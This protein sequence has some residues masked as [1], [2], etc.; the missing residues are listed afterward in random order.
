MKNLLDTKDRLARRCRLEAFW[1][2]TAMAIVTPAVA[3]AQEGS[4]IQGSAS[5]SPAPEQTIGATD[6]TGQD[7][8]VTGIRAGLE[9]SINVK[10]KAVNVVDVISAED[11][12]KFPDNN[13]AESLQ[14]IPSVTI[15]RSELG[16]GR[17]INLRGLGTGFTRTEINGGFAINGLD[18]GVLAPEIFSRVAV[19]K[20]SSAS[21][22]E[23]GLAG[24]V[25]I[26]TIKPFDSP[27]LRI[28]AV[29]GGQVGQKSKVMPRTFGLISKNWDDRFGIALGVAYSKVDFRTNEIAYGPWVPF[30]LIANANALAT[31]PST[32]LDAATPRTAA[33]Y[34]YIEQRKN[35]GGTAAFQAKLGDGFDL[36]ADFLYAEI[37]GARHDDRPD[38][39]IEGNNAAPTNYTVE[40]GVVTSGTFAGVQNRVGTSYRPQ[41]QRVWQGTLRADL[42]PN[43][44]LTVSPAIA[45]AKRNERTEL[46]L[47]S[48]AIN[49][50]TAS[51]DVN[52][53]VPNFTSGSTDFLSN[54]QDFG[55]NVFIFDRFRQTTDELMAKI[56]AKYAFDDEDRFS[57]RFG[58]RYTDR[59]TSRRGENAGLYQGSPL[60]TANS[61]SLAGVAITRPFSVKGSPSQT[62]DRI[63]AVDPALAKKY[64]YPNVGDPYVAPEFFPYLTGN[65][66]RSFA[67]REETFAGY[68]QANFV[69]G[70]VSF[71]VGIRYVNTS[72][73]TEGTQLVGETPLARSDSGKSA[74]W[75]PAANARWEPIQNVVVHGALSRSLTR[76]DLDSLTPTQY[77]NSGPQTGTR[78]NPNLRPYTADQADLSVEWYW[79]PGSLLNVGYFY[80]DIKDL[81]T[82]RTVNEVATFPDQLTGLPTTGVIAF[83]EPANGNSAWVSGLEVGL[84]S[85]FYFLPGALSGF[86]TVLNYTRAANR[87]KIDNPDGTTLRQDL[88]GLSRNAYNAVLYYEKSG[89]DAR[90][91]YSWRSTYR[92][93]DP[94]GAQFGAERYVRSFGQLDFSSSLPVTKWLQLNFDV[95]NVLD[96]QRKEFIRIPSTGATPPANVIEL[97]RR[98]IVTARAVF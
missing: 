94:V 59:T 83:T 29:G 75:L 27:G 22:V 25:K 2:G 38:V 90:F 16:E 66:L 40:D 70:A 74:N 23:G 24:T 37:D 51:Y 52:G 53:S 5:A 3:K 43:E 97:E 14:R 1:L 21:S 96:K 34:S 7:I 4:T 41:Y 82:Q 71:D 10:R 69:I 93:S 62:P 42:R 12:G 68:A 61:P 54:P 49:N 47:F 65:D 84:Q 78:G 86:G 17:Q 30:R 45:F 56:D 85:P 91:A 48:F 35:I 58:G 13:L 36:T 44:H 80:K 64:F 33:Y 63:L 6:D 46:Q 28:V 32:L 77:I 87:A 50:T 8:V 73:R 39:P 20:S 89:F 95:T 26:E 79:H 81:I 57:I 76:P 9:R 92:R 19:E 67:V 15:D 55:F 72:T 98:F 18:L 88:P 31:A 11:I 60:L